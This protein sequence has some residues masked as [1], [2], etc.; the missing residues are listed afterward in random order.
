MAG[1]SDR[2]P[3]RGAW[4]VLTPDRAVAARRLYETTAI[5]VARI[6]QEVGVSRGTILYH[7]NR[8]RWLRAS[9]AAKPRFGQGT[10]CLGL[11]LCPLRNAIHRRLFDSLEAR[12]RLAE[13]RG[14]APSALERERDMRVLSALTRMLEKLVAMDRDAVREAG[15]ATT[16]G[17]AEDAKAPYDVEALRRELTDSLD[18]LHRARTGTTAC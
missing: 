13:S 1:E 11:A 3:G 14:E 16:P 5:P 9:T 17:T 15:G 4:R 10:L 12:I 8:E 2:T 6:A 7:A 18:R